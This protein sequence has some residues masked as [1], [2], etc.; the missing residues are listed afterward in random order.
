[1]TGPPVF[2]LYAWNSARSLPRGNR[3][4]GDLAHLIEMADLVRDAV[5][6]CRR[7]V[8]EAHAL[9]ITRRHIA[10]HVQV[11]LVRPRVQVG[12]AHAAALFQALDALRLRGD[13]LPGC[14]VARALGSGDAPR[15]Q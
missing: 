4:P 12:Q 13:R 9:G 10:L 5:N 1:M 11:R 14:F 6:I 15:Q 2:A 7:R 8:D 3:L